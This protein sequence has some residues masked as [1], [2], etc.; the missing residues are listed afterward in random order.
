ML[1]LWQFVSW[2]IENNLHIDQQQYTDKQEVLLEAIAETG[3]EP[4]MYALGKPAGMTEE[5]MRY[6]EE[7]FR[8]KPWGVLNYQAS[9]DA[10]M[11][12]NLLRGFAVD[13]VIAFILFSMLA[14][15]NATALSDALFI[16]VGIGLVAFL[17]EPYI[18]HI[19]YKTPGMFAH[20]IDA[21]VPWSLLGA[22]W[23]KM[24]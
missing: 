11:G 4:G 20:L 21:V 12:S 19:W 6:W 24:K 22:I 23:W 10:N 9:F 2:G 13:L 18:Y 3:L 17:A 15:V 14:K 16:T 7:T 8:G 1:F 5:D